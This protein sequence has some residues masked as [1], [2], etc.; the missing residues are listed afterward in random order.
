MVAVIINKSIAPY[1]I[2]PPNAL[3]IR[4]KIKR[5]PLFFQFFIL[6]QNRY[7]YFSNYG[8]FYSSEN[9]YQLVHRIFIYT[10]QCTCIICVKFV[11]ILLS[12]NRSIVTALTNKIKRGFLTFYWRA[13]DWI[14]KRRK[15]FFD[16]NKYLN[17]RW[18]ACKQSC[19]LQKYLEFCCRF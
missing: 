8:V 13:L 1:I 15:N 14:V 3:K 4:T 16:S 19:I 17:H 9:K 5:S 2:G 12:S 11:M 6:L 7:T 10:V 18:F